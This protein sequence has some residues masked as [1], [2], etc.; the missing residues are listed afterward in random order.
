[1]TDEIQEIEKDSIQRSP[2]DKQN[3][4]VMTNR[5]TIQDKRL[6]WQ[7]TGLLVYLLSLPSDWKII[8][9]ELC[10]HKTNGRD[11]TRSAFD[12]L[13]EHK[14]IMT[15][16][17]Y[18]NNLRNGFA[19]Y[20]YER[21]YTF[22]DEELV[23]NCF[24]HAGFQRA[25]NPTLH[26]KQSSLEN[27]HK[28]IK[29]NIQKKRETEANAS[30]ASKEAHVSV[31]FPNDVLEYVELLCKSL[32]SLKADYKITDRQKLEWAKDIDKMIRVDLRNP[33]EIK[34]LLTWLPTNDFWPKNIKSGKKFREKYDDLWVIR[35]KEIKSN[36]T[37]LKE[38]NAK[39]AKEKNIV[40]TKRLQDK[41]EKLK[42]LGKIPQD[43][44]LVI[45]DKGVK[46]LNCAGY[47]EYD[48][49]DEAFE[50]TLLLMFGIK[51]ED[52]NG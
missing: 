25:E 31:S 46:N 10:N 44:K 8:K 18:K 4:Y 37:K 21:P 29:E 6:S 38:F 23:K 42:E 32:R 40:L 27:R 36:P 15:I 33:Q 30:L 3:P 52:L 41:F 26:N 24:R 1:M 14:Y 13:I 20:L 35:D 5:E 51:N 16:Q 48:M 11:A 7:A 34:G 28:D 39:I 2:H 49:N 50:K 9:D 12:E 45:Y 22:E 47:L 43:K 19:Y 17:L